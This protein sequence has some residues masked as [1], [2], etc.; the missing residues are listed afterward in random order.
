MASWV[1]PALSSGLSWGLRASWVLPHTLGFS[2]PPVIQ[3][4]GNSCQMLSG[5]GEQ[6]QGQQRRNLHRDWMDG[7]TDG[8]EG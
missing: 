8:G 2:E 6:G 5:L 3:G 4:G 1:L 7:E